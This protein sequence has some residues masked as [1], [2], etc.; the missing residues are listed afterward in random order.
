MYQRKRTI[1]VCLMALLTGAANGEPLHVYLTYSGAP[2]SS[3]DINVIMPEKVAAVGVYLDTE[4]CHENRG[5]YRHTFEAVYQP[6]ALELADERALYAAQITGLEP[7]TA[8]HFVAGDEEYGY[9]R[10]LKF[11]TLPGGPA[12]FR[13]V[14]GGDMGVDN[15]AKAILKQA[16][17]TD[18]DFAVIGGDFAYADGLIGN[19]GL[20]D[21]W[22]T[23]W[24]TWM[25]RTDGFQ[26]P[27][28][29]A[30]GNHEVNDYE[31]DRDELRAPWYLGLF[32]RQSDEVYFSRPV[33]DNVVFLILDSGYLNPF[34]DRQQTWLENELARYQD[35]RYKFAVYHMPLYPAFTA[36]DS[37]RK[38]EA[39]ELWGTLFDRYGLTIGFEHDDHVMK[40]S[41][42]LK[43]DAIVDG[44][45]VYVGDGAFGRESRN[46][47]RVVRWYNEVE[48]SVVHFWLVDVN[49]E[50]LH[51]RAIDRDGEAIDAFEIP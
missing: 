3:I 44:G 6:T 5:R 36:Y 21:A 48:E 20:W 31:A 49:P 24:N 26:V 40:R 1:V 39:R 51:L 30:I 2:E 13:F 41:K 29:A 50:G 37:P 28:V 4:P 42:P 9:T 46:V 38:V 12:P 14:A 8:Y 10:E 43:G 17:K 15:R 27:I 45:T 47:D 22:L 25:V 19:S 11:R 18:P 16:G 33:G 7:G 34:G 32:G 35:V 23:N